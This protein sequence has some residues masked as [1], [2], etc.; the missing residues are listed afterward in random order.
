MGHFKPLYFLCLWGA[1]ILSRDAFTL[2]GVQG[3]RVQEFTVPGLGVW[4]AVWQVGFRNLRPRLMQALEAKN[5]RLDVYH[6]T[7]ADIAMLF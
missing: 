4:G 5:I 6:G 2:L 7:M 1:G 3:S